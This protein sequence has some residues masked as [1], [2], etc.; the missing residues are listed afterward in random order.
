MKKISILLAFLLVGCSASSK[1]ITYDNYIGQASNIPSS[2]TN[3]MYDIT[4]NLEL[5]ANDEYI[6]QVIIDNP[7]ELMENIQIVAVHNQ[8]TDDVFPS[9]GIFDGNYSLLVDGKTKGINLVGYIKEGS[10]ETVT[11]KVMVKYNNITNYHI[12]KLDKN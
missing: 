7:K 1:Q 12:F 3:Y 8:T 9:I 5:F 4:A 2:T 11:I 6:Y 10:Y